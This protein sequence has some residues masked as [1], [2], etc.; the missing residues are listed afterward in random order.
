MASSAA[1]YHI[2]ALAALALPSPSCSLPRASR[3]ASRVRVII[4]HIP[5]DRCI[6]ARP[7]CARCSLVVVVHHAWRADCR[8]RRS[9]RAASQAATFGAGAPHGAC[10]SA[11]HGARPTGGSGRLS[12]CPAWRLCDC[13]AWRLCECWHRELGRG[14]RH[15]TKAAQLDPHGS[16]S[17]ALGS[18]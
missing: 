1:R 4:A 8:R 16:L 6:G 9:Q 2:I 12:D 13:P 18:L 3:H 7:I 11:R 17:H 10:V 15:H 14:V 5:R